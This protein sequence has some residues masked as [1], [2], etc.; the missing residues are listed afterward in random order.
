M[1]IRA[2]CNCAT[3]CFLLLLFLRT[4]YDTRLHS[5]SIIY[6]IYILATE[7]NAFLSLSPSIILKARWSL[8]HC[9]FHSSLNFFVIYPS[10]FVARFSLAIILHH[11]VSCPTIYANCPY[12]LLL[13]RFRSV[14]FLPSV[15]NIAVPCG[16]QPFSTFSDIHFD[17]LIFHLHSFKGYW[18]TRRLYTTFPK[19]T[20]VYWCICRTSMSLRLHPHHPRHTRVD[21]V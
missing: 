17:F 10:S 1:S 13:L 9:H 7:F 5:E 14:L 16:H 8:F 18:L 6:I 20:Q 2:I 11:R 21:I 3:V 4:P 12:L 15:H 19:L